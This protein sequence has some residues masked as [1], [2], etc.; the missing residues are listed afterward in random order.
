MGL[1]Y[2]FVTFIS[3]SMKSKKHESGSSELV[4]EQSTQAELIKK[5][6]KLLM[7]EREERLRDY[8]DRNR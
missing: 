8:K 7:E 4:D 6:Q 3:K 2:G 1:F 5:K